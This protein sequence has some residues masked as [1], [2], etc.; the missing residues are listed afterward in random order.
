MTSCADR[1]GRALIRHLKGRD[2][3]LA[4]REDDIFALKIEL[5]GFAQVL[6]RFL[7][8]A[9]LAGDIDLGTRRYEPVP[10]LVDDC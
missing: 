6:D 9:A 8:C 10:F 3:G 4:V 7:D 2:D 1:R 5:D